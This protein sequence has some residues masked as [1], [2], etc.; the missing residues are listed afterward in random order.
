MLARCSKPLLRNA[1]ICPRVRVSRYP[2]QGEPER[3]I[4]TNLLRVMRRRYVWWHANTEEGSDTMRKT[5]LIVTFSSL[6]GALV[7]APL[8]V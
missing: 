1:A 6:L 2:T 5:I 4:H 8:A 3:P 7:A